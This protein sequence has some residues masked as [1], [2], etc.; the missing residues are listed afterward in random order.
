MDIP[1]P[2]QHTMSINHKPASEMSFKCFRCCIAKREEWKA[3]EG[4]VCDGGGGFGDRLESPVET[5]SILWWVFLHDCVVVVFV[6]L[7]GVN[8]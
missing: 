8:C 2:S 5:H 1:Y 6:R 3:G 7:G 4:C